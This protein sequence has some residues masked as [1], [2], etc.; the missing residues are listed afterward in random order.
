MLIP[1]LYTKHMNRQCLALILFVLATIFVN[2]Q[3]VKAEQ[4]S[5]ETAKID[6]YLDT[7]IAATHAPNTQVAV[8]Q[9]GVVS[10]VKNFGPETTSQSTFSIGSVSKPLTAYG[11]LTLAQDGKLK[12]TDPVSTFLPNLGLPDQKTT[13]HITIANL[14]K[15]TSGLST[16]DGRRLFTFANGASIQQNVQTLSGTRLVSKPGEKYEYSNANYEILGAIIEKVSGQSYAD[17]MAKSVFHSNNMTNTSA[18]QSPSI[19]GFQSWYGFSFQSISPYDQASAPYGFISSSA[20]DLA[21]FLVNQMDTHNNVAH[22]MLTEDVAIAPD[23]SHSLGW[24]VGRSNGQLIVFHSGENADY[25]SCVVFNPVQ[26]YGIV[27]L[28][29][30]QHPLNSIQSCE[31]AEGVEAILKNTIPDTPVAPNSY[32]RLIDS[33]MA[34]ATPLLLLGYFRLR[35]TKKPSIWQTIGLLS[36]FISLGTYPLVLYITQAQLQ[37]FLLF[38]PDMAVSIA[39]FSLLTLL[40]SV[41]CFYRA[42]HAAGH[43]KRNK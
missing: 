39:V 29:N 16:Y 38:A 34:I 40:F 37:T 32:I 19:K 36:G 22:T 27:V 7:A 5:P 18:S 41:S 30:L 4:S 1:L 11:V 28:N 15:H 43:T 35:P 33:V 31:V 20:T 21:N 8:I 13:S 25:G 14:L 6:T 3:S 2:A 12:L 23:S 24:F 26:R 42:I 9:N 10:M 17:F